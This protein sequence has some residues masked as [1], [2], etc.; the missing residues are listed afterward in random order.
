MTIRYLKVAF[1]FFIGVMALVYALQNV[2]N[3]EAAY[4][5]VGAVLGMEN[6]EY[7]ASSLGPAIK[8]PAL[9]WLAVATIILAETAAGVLA[10]L[11]SWKLW[12]A[13]HAT[14]ADFNAAKTLTLLGC[15]IGVIVWFGFFGSVGA[16]WFQMWQTELG[17]MSLGG[18]FQ[19][20]VYC[21]LVLI[22]VNMKDD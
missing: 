4:A 21:A 14:G 13:R 17:A 11:G 15:G 1:V 16:A 12:R 22:F 2:V 20:A 19:N 9:V 7:Y 6:H 8:S 10:L 5:V 3:I 18:A